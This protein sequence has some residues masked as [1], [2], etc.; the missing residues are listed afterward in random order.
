MMAFLASL[1]FAFV[2]AFLMAAVI[3]WLDRY[4]KEPLILLGAAFF[5]GAIVAAGGAFIL[6]TVFGLGIYALTGSGDVADQATASLIAPFVEEALKGIAVLLVFLFFRQEFDSILDGIIYAAITAL[7]FAATENVL[8][9]YKHGYVD[10][11]GW[12][13]FWQLVIIR[14]VVVAWQ[15]PYFTAFTGIGLAVARL[16]RNML[17]KIV[18]LPVGY[19]FA[20]FAHAFHN[21]FGSLIGGLA[22]FAIG[23]LADWLGWLIMAVFIVFMIARERRVLVNQL[24]EEVAAGIITAAQYRRA[25]SPLT[26][27]TAFWMGGLKASRFYRACGELAYKKE[28]LAR[29][30]DERG[31]ALL[32]QSLRKEL[33]ALAPQ[34]RA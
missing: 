3:Y 32:V 26:M 34:V 33:A 14:D 31:N 18:A 15:H 20:V 11:G 23:S 29:L 8:Y 4:E 9:I 5:W 1:F 7:G 13:G 28:E 30:G 24:R 27:S 2:P 17:V 6:N 16:S 22:G 25:L 10:G 12:S 21:S 19:A